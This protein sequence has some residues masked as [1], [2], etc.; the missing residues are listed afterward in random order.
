MI[1]L[2]T[3]KE[4]II[5]V[6]IFPCIKNIFL[7]LKAWKA[8]SHQGSIEVF[9]SLSKA[10]MSQETLRRVNEFDLSWLWPIQNK[11]IFKVK[12]NSKTQKQ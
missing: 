9:S 10:A 12:I 6:I 5:A 8:N 4:V 2:Y 11:C 7:L 1:Y 3:L